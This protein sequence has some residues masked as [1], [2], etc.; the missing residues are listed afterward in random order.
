M[1]YNRLVQR[2]PQA[3]II[4]IDEV[5]FNMSMMTMMGR[6]LIG[7]S[8]TKVVRQLRSRNIYIVCA[9]NRSGILHYMMRNRAINQQSFIEFIRELKQK[10]R[11]QTAEHNPVLIM[12]NVAFHKCTAVRETILQE[13]CDVKYLPPYSPFLNPIENLFSKWKKFVNRANPQNE[14][15]LMTAIGNGSSLITSVDCDGYFSNMW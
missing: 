13:G 14:Q 10:L 7:T 11:D 3:A 2:L 4:F 15:E 8:A 1:A 6:S 12:D 9:M 5:G